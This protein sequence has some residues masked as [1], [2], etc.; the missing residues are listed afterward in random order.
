MRIMEIWRYP[1][2]SMGGESLH[3]AEVGPD[4]VVGDRM[5]GVYDPATDMVLTAR[6]EPSLLFLRAESR[7]GGRPAIITDE[8]VEIAD[9][10]ALSAWIGRPVSLR[11]ADDGPGTFENPMNVDDESDWVRWQSA[12]RTFHDGRSTVSLVSSTSLGAWD[13]RRFRINLITDGSGEDDLSGDLGIGSVTLSLRK[14]IDRCVMV[15]RAQP[16]IERDLTVLKRVI[17]ERDN[18]MGVGAVVATPGTISTGDEVT[19]RGS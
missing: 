5:W 17:A 14:P 11:C 16:G 18:Q 10:E 15:T 3:T 7:D 4:G 12:G 13:A 1:V 19:P 9:D 2:K 6:R 8:G